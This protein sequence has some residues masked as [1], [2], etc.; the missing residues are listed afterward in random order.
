MPNWVYN[1]INGYT[2]DVHDKYCTENRDIDFNKVIPEPE[3]ITN[4]VCGS[5]NKISKDIANYKKYVKNI[6]ESNYNS[7]FYDKNNPLREPFDN[8]MTNTIKDMGELAI[9]SPDESL[10]TI[11]SKDANS[12]YRREY[13]TYTSIFGNSRYSRAN[14]GKEVFDKYIE[15][16]N[17]R[18]LNCKLD[19]S[20]DDFYNQFDNLEE[21]GDKLLELKEK[22]GYDN[23]YDWRL[24][25]WGCK[26]NASDSEYDGEDN[27]RF[28]TPWSIPYPVIAKIAEDNPNIKLDGYSE[29]E[30]G[31][32]ENYNTENGKVNVTSAGDYIYDEES[33]ETRDVLDDNFEPRSF[34]YKEITEE[35]QRELKLL[36]IVK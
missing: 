22:Y 16:K 7:I 33:D 9:E 26:W 14:K 36:N 24:A 35:I 2:K 23:W 6:E 21:M 19:L 29:E 20:S 1:S 13:D 34:T 30:S 8:E 3:E 32:Y 11:L 10:N 28:D 31:W 15:A 25:N 17:D 4:T 5:F 18:F 12:C 27:V